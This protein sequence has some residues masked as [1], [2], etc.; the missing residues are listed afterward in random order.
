MSNN[1]NLTNEWHAAFN[2]PIT[3]R[4][5][6][7][8]EFYLPYAFSCL[9]RVKSESNVPDVSN[10]RREQCETKF[11]KLLQSFLLSQ[12]GGRKKTTMTRCFRGYV[13]IQIARG[14]DI[15]GGYK[16]KHTRTRGCPRRQRFRCQLSSAEHIFLAWNPFFKPNFETE[17]RVVVRINFLLT[18]VQEIEYTG[19]GLWRSGAGRY[20]CQIIFLLSIIIF[21]LPLFWFYFF[22]FFF[23]PSWLTV[24]GQ[25]KVRTPASILSDDLSNRNSIPWC[26]I[27]L[28]RKVARQFVLD[29][30]GIRR[31]II[32]AV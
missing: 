10:N 2:E 7:K 12:L 16:Y 13:R 32:I 3:D 31:L 22:R 30:E 4:V 1:I 17:R 11:S 23:P 19:N 8:H 6:K 24:S 18:R 5:S 28:N 20:L 26:Y 15:C 27:A 9:E 21:F 14:L 29:G 25:E